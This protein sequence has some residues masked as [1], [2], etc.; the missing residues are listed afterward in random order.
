VPTHVEAGGVQPFCLRLELDGLQWNPHLDH[1]EELGVPGCIVA[2]TN[3]ENVKGVKYE[4]ALGNV[5]KCESGERLLL[6]LCCVRLMKTACA[7]VERQGIVSLTNCRVRVTSQLV[8]SMRFIRFASF[9]QEKQKQKTKQKHAKKESHAANSN[10]HTHVAVDK[11][12]CDARTLGPQLPQ[13]RPQQAA[14]VGPLARQ[15]VAA[16][17]LVHPEGAV[18]V[19]VP[20]RRPVVAVVVAAAVPLLRPQEEAAVGEVPRRHLPGVGEVLLV[21]QPRVQALLVLLLPVA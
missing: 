8:G 14:A 21:P 20:P 16:V 19:E 17:L 12:W 6:A 15:V 4:F 1:L 3:V 18:V 5:R 13:A 10:V 7:L 2:K 11:R 9:R